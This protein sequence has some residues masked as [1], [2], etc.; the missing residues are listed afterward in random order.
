ME[1][2]FLTRLLDVS[3][4]AAPGTAWI[5]I[6]ALL[7]DWV[8]GDP[9]WL[10]RFVPHPVVL[11][12]KLIGFLDRKLNRETRAQTDRHIR[13]AIAVVVTVGIAA[14]VGWGVQDVAR[15]IPH[16]WLI[17]AAFAGVLIA[18][19]D[20]WREVGR[21]RRALVKE[22]LEAGR[23][24][25]GRI[26]GRDP[27]S[28]DKHGVARAAVESL[29]ENFADGVVAP[30]FWFLLFG[31]PGLCAYKAINTLD[32]MIGYK[33]EKYKAFGYVAAKLDD[34]ANWIPARLSA[35]LTL[36]AAIPMPDVDPHGGWSAI[37]R[38]A[39]KHKSPNA[40]WPEAA[41]AGALGLALGGPRH[42]PGV[43][44]VGV[45]IGDGKARLE[46]KDIARACRLFVG[47]NIIMLLAVFA[48]AVLG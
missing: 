35:V 33:S 27:K 43:G 8:V 21:V 47:A 44:N 34:A 25:V 7:I 19:R 28:L 4:A 12:G 13:G 11:I 32:S 9:P 1:S 29:S 26:V 42:Y 23:V 10:Y 41:F 48:A 31:L 20:L 40:G 30:A 5:L 39:G 36:I 24:A 2:E 17:E 37:K 3:A 45:W 16:G 15:K 6:V 38:D 18:A 14:L 46:P 22:G